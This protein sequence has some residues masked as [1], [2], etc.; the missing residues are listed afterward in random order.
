MEEGEILS[1]ENVAGQLNVSI[2]PVR[3]AFQILDRLQ[4]TATIK[5]AVILK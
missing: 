1:L 5:I 3:E 4:P 2:T